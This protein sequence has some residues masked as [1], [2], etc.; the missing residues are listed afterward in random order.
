MVRWS[1]RSAGARNAQDSPTAT[2]ILQQGPPEAPQHGSLPDVPA[3][4]PVLPL[5]A[6]K[7]RRTWLPFCGPHPHLDACNGAEGNRRLT[8]Q[9]V[10]L[11]KSAIAVWLPPPPAV[12]HAA[13]E[14]GELQAGPQAV[15]WGPRGAPVTW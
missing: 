2:A 15:A 14:H 1:A 5:V 7:G 6:A 3:A 9:G 8:C 10:T 11:A 12:A 13:G 4:E